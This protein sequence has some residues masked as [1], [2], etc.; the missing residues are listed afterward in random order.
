M[1]FIYWIVGIV[2][3]LVL[4]A[5]VGLFT[6]LG[7]GMLK[8]I[9]ESKIKEQTKLE[10]SLTRFSLGV[11]SLHIALELNK[12]NTIAIDGTYSL[13]AQSFDLTY[14]VALHD[15]ASLKPLTKTKLNDSFFTEGVIRG[16]SK[17]LKIKGVSD[18][19][20]SNTKYD[21]VL[22]N[23]NPTSIIAKVDNLDLASLLHMLNQKE[24]AQAKVD[25]V[26]NFKNITPHQL[27]GD[28]SLVTKKG[29]LNSAVMKKD[30]KI[31]V[32]KTLFAMK[33]KA[34]LKGDDIDYSYLLDSNLAKI[35]SAGKIKP[36]PLTLA[37]TYGLNVKELAVLKPVTHADVRGPLRLS[38]SVK[39]T[40]EK[41]VVK[42][43]SDIAASNTT[44]A[45]LLTNFSPKSVQANIRDLHVQKLLYMLKQ[46]HYTDA[47]VDI[48]ANITNADV[49]NLQGDVTT[50]L[51]KG[52]LDAKLLTKMYKFKSAMPKVSYGMRAYTT[53]DKNLIDTKVDFASNL[54]N[55]N[56]KKARFDMNDA[57]LKSDYKVK[58][59][60]LDRL[61]FV[62]QR[63]LQGA[64][65]ANGEVKKAKD[66]DFTMHSNI[67][68]GKV[69][70]KLHNDDFHAD[71]NK[72]R[73]LDILDILIYPK[74]FAADI[75]AKLD[76]NL[77]AEKGDFKGFLSQGKFTRNR[78]LDLT[79][80]YAHIDLYK[81]LFKGDVSAKINK[82][83]ILASLDLKSNT[84]SI[85]TTNTKL[86]SKTKRIDSV[87]EINANGNPL[88][89]KLR[90][91]ASSPQ[92]SVDASKI[93]KKEAEKA[94]KKELQKHLGKDINKLFKGLF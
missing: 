68:G 28:V 85:K 43:K 11:S 30:F 80:Q 39:G 50:V 66:L 18:V 24:Y 91:N 36:E 73:T 3:G 25:V 77:A 26:A 71:I 31:T 78:V 42:G 37:L 6:S 32:P 5:Y 54:A 15:L 75:D 41:L 27:D 13:F 9:L 34:K 52:L 76:Y 33:L 35:N 8:P 59:H 81:Q 12:N 87:I 40:K 63:H 55:L 58:I 65:A 48:K 61:Y 69:D 92:V 62:T 83:H 10:S 1:K 45:A 90:G 16:D 57:S 86:N 2:V 56:V 74:V 47:L 79:K 14:K 53:L 22:T 64:F 17:L 67:A 82:E 88:V 84:S 4:L 51:K 72:L 29:L 23:F 49:K 94:V 7:N 89:V 44:F 20:K 93:V 46:P 21:V 60:N 19:A 70:A 38:G